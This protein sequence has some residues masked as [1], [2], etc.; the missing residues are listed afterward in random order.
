MWGVE[1]T[2]VVQDMLPSLSKQTN[3]QTKNSH[4]F[5]AVVF[6]LFDIKDEPKKYWG[7]VGVVIHNAADF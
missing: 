3:K 1:D 4:S 6:R 7:S 5:R 2:Y